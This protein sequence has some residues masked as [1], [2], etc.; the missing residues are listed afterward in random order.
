L[1]ELGVIIEVAKAVEQIALEN[2][3]TEVDTI[4]LQIGEISSMIPRYI[5]ECYPAAVDGTMLEKTKLEIEIIL[6][7]AQC[8]ACDTHFNV[9]E[10]QGYCPNCQTKDWNLI[11]G[12]EFM[13]KEII[14][15]DPEEKGEVNHE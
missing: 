14:V 8:K 13:I 2:Q 6:A 7:T 9:V 11:S 12:K 3:I 15:R 10:N 1:H 5:Q 4:V